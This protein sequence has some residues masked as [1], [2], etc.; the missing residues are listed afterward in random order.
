MIF[1]D[2]QFAMSILTRV[3]QVFST[4]VTIMISLYVYLVCLIRP[5]DYINKSSEAPCKDLEPSTEAIID[6]SV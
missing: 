3:A 2:S 6:V 4:F 1:R 5:T